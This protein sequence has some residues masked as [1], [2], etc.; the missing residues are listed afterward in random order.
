MILI[1][2]FLSLIAVILAFVVIRRY[3]KTNETLYNVGWSDGW[4][5]GINERYIDE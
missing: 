5:D 1:L 3:E 2:G 4:K